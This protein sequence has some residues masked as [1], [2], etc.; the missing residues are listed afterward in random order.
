MRNFSSRKYSDN[1]PQTNYNQLKTDILINIETG[2][3]SCLSH[4]SSNSTSK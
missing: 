4:S 2:S 1:T 3:N